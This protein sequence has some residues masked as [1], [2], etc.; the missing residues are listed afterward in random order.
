MAV[1]ALAVFCGHNKLDRY[2]TSWSW[3]RGNPIFHRNTCVDSCGSKI[4]YNLYNSIAYCIADLNKIS[5]KSTIVCL[6]ELSN[7]HSLN[8]EFGDIAVVT[9]RSSAVFISCWPLID[10]ASRS[11]SFWVCSVNR[12]IQAHLHP[13]EESVNKGHLYH[14][15]AFNRNEPTTQ[16]AFPML[17]GN[18][19]CSESAYA[20]RRALQQAPSDTDQTVQPWPGY[21]VI[22]LC[23]NTTPRP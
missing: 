16:I 14:P 21:R 20:D 7:N 23:T 8:H 15:Y 3:W 12:E 6:N 2:P 4:F 5:N 19:K 18:R 1:L 17:S 11:S 10:R 22:P 13:A 9:S